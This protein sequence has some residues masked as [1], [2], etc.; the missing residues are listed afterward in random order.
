MG[1][2]A[3]VW[4]AVP[5]EGGWVEG[6]PHQVYHSNTQQKDNAALRLCNAGQ[7]AQTAG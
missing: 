2:G 3:A 7:C 6:Y 5:L 4:N 1:V